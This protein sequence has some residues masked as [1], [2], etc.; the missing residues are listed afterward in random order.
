MMLYRVKELGPSESNRSENSNTSSASLPLDISQ[1]L[2]NDLELLKHTN[3]R[4]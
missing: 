2:R 3:V 4:S 1:Q